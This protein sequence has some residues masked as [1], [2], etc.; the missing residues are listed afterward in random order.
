VAILQLFNAIEQIY[1]KLLDDESREIFLKRLKYSLS[2]DKKYL[3]EMIKNLM[4]LYKDTDPVMGL[5]SWIKLHNNQKLII[6]G[7]GFAGREIIEALNLYDIRPVCICDNSQ[8]I[9]GTIR[10]GLPI[11]SPD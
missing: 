5:I 4:E 6:F 1:S 3:D 11:V 2:R 8:C 9:Q 10:Y 7:A